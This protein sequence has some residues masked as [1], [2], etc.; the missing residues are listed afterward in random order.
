MN[1]RISPYLAP[2]SLTCSL[3][4]LHICFLFS[5][6]HLL[7]CLNHFTSISL[8]IWTIPT[9][10]QQQHTHTH[11]IK[12]NISSPPSFSLCYILLTIHL[13]RGLVSV[14]VIDTIYERLDHNHH[15]ISDWLVDLSHHTHYMHTPYIS[16]VDYHDNDYSLV[17]F[18]VSLLQHLE[19]G[20]MEV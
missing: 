9:Q 3:F 12:F 4:A 10:Q 5:Q 13:L 19:L 18:Y 2:I 11:T 14:E 8:T 17:S 15:T 1:D 6:S 16:V 20:G 7:S